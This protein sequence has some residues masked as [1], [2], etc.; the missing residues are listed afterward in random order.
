MSD[1]TTALAASQAAASAPSELTLEQIVENTKTKVDSVVVGDT[2][3]RAHVQGLMANLLDSIMKGQVKVSDD[4]VASIDEQIANMDRLLS[5]QLGAIM[6]HDKFQKL[7]ASWTGLHHMVHTAETGTLLKVKVLNANKNEIGRDLKRAMDFD[8]SQMFLKI[9]EDEYGKLGGEP[10]SIII[11]DFQFNAKNA[12]D[13]EFLQKMSSVAAAAH[14]PFIAAASPESFGIS[15]FTELNDIYDLAKVFDHRL[16]PMYT[17]WNSFRESPDSRYAA[18]TVPGYL[19]RLPYGKG[20]NE[21]QI[22][23]FAFDENVDGRNHG[24]YLWCN[25][26]YMLGEKVAEAFVDTGWYAA[27]RGVENG[28]LAEDLP[29]H[30]VRTSEGDLSAKCP[31]EISIG[32]RR[33]KELSD[34]GF[35]PMVHYKGTDRAVI[36]SVQ[37]CQKPAVYT[38]DHATASAR[39]T[40]NLSYLLVISRIAHYLQAICRDK[41]GSYKSR[42]DTQDL[43]Q[44]WLNR[45]CLENPTSDDQKRKYPLKSAKVEVIDDPARPGCYKAVAYVQPHFQMEEVQVSLRLV[46]DLPDKEA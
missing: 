46:A 19:G 44:Q 20:D 9:Y 7:E 33:E 8:Q 17:K 21:M 31:I 34:L 22:Q 40:S 27:I 37:S 2:Q 39:L 38:T 43:L 3:E 5:D 6:H 29:I 13:V 32:D 4:L 35:I 11:G 16:N 15:S 25:A 41:I 45:Y 14:A 1:S 36:M 24:D 18:L 26:A 10:Y 42:E 30:V 12:A 23:E 28:G